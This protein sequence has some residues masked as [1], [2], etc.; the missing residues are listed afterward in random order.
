[1]SDT[2]I[3]LD[4]VARLARLKITEEEKSEFAPQLEKILGYIDTLNEI[5]V[6]DIEPTAHATPVYAVPREDVPGVS[7]TQELAMQNAPASAQ[8]QIK[9]P[10]VVES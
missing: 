2:P 1:M 6:S 4:Y 5:D 7:F 9:V 8:E 10:R 3:N